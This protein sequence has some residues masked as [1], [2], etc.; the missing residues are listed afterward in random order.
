MNARNIRFCVEPGDLPA[1][2]R[3]IR[4]L[5]RR[6]F[7]VH[8]WRSVSDDT[9]HAFDSYKRVVGTVKIA[10]Y[11]CKECGAEKSFPHDRVDLRRS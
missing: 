6:L 2:P 9:Y 1:A 10:V 7:C 4:S 3:P 8:D 5:L 11:V